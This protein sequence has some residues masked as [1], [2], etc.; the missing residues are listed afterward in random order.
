MTLAVLQ[1]FSATDEVQSAVD[2]I[3]VMPFGEFRVAVQR[4]AQPMRIV[5]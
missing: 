2:R 4:G 1:I 5:L 3:E